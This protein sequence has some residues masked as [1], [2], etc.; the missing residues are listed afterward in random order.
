MI[1]I[2]IVKMESSRM[3]ELITITAAKADIMSKKEVITAIMT[4]TVTSI[5]IVAVVVAVRLL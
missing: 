4:A 1:S 2:A 3:A 5:A